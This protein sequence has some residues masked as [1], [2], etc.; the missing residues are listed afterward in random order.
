MFIPSDSPDLQR[1]L[2]DAAASAGL[3]RVVPIPG[4]GYF[5][6]PARSSGGTPAVASVEC[7]CADSA[8][9]PIEPSAELS[10]EQKA[11]FRC[12]VAPER[13]DVLVI[14]GP[15]SG[16]TKTLIS[17]IVGAVRSGTPADKI[18]AISFT[19]NS[20]AELKVRLCKA[21]KNFPSLHRVHVST[22]HAWVCQLAASR[23][24]PWTYPPVRL[25]DASLAVALHITNPDST[26]AFS[27]TE[28]MAADRHLEGCETFWAMIGRNYKN[29]LE[30]PAKLQAFRNLEAAAVTAS[31][32]FQ[33]KQISTYGS[34][35]RSGIALAKEL[36]EDGLGWLF[37]DEAQDLNS[38]QADFA[39]SVQ[40]KTKCRI[41]AIADDDQG[42]YKFRGASNIFLDALRARSATTE[43]FG[44]TKNFRS[45]QA[46]VSLCRNWIRPN[47][48]KSCA[49]EKNYSSQRSGL[50]TVILT[51]SKPWDRG[52]HA[53]IL[54]DAAQK[55][56]GLI[57]H[58]GHSAALTFSTKNKLDI[59]LRSH[60]QRVHVLKE[61]LLEKD[62]LDDFL[63]KLTGSDPA[64]NW[65]HPIWIDF[66]ESVKSAQVEA[67]KKTDKTE[68]S[69]GHPGLNDLYSA[70]EVFR[71][72]AP[73]LSPKEAADI[74]RNAAVDEKI[75]FSGEGM[76]PDYAGDKINYLTL[77]SCKGLEFRVV[78][79]CGGASAFA[80]KT[81][82]DK[83][84]QPNTS[85]KAQE[86][87]KFEDLEDEKKKLDRIAD[88]RARTKEAFEQENRRLLYVGMSRATDLLILS[89][90]R[91]SG[92]KHNQYMIRDNLFRDELDKALLGAH[93][94]KI[95]T[96]AEAHAFAAT[97][98]AAHR[99][100][101]WQ[102]PHRYRVESFT[103]LTRQLQPGENR[104]V[105]IPRE[106][107]YPLP[108]SEDAMIGDL[109]HRIMHL[110]CMEPETLRQRLD[111]KMTDADLIARVSTRN[112]ATELKPLA[113]FLASYFADFTN[114]PW[115]LLANAR[116][117][118]PFSH[119]KNASDSTLSAGL[120]GRGTR[121]ACPHEEKRTSG[122]LVP[123]IQAIDETDHEEFLLKGFL[124]LVRF[125]DDGAPSLILDYKTGPTPEP[126]D[127]KHAAQLRCYREALAESYSCEIGAIKL[128]NYYVATQV[129]RD[130]S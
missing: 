46:I 121:P 124:D 81:W 70:V 78:W 96:D 55:P 71:R 56:G 92:A 23:I 35:M 28:I 108:Q 107:E 73:D 118:V 91:H 22:F 12:V 50:P 7:R 32:Q 80:P 65:H 51:A 86:D 105:E 76:Q 106:R 26:Q 84:G 83:D 27:R 126:D 36:D 94:I 67:A 95:S 4:L 75:G 104:E 114:K 127:L 33:E 102:P 21:A 39:F 89:A 116:S 54:F 57:E 45:T 90:P 74:L 8:T 115:E 97:I 13:K 59:E 20:A 103:S 17:C 130:R 87:F 5:A 60:A 122:P 40:Q 69:F 129:L 120:P 53:M 24:D 38:T 125:G 109:F 31:S 77:H 1:K 14:A 9:S 25:A 82:D 18:V 30:D 37:I 110:L 16:K 48:E 11:V 58:F 47:W 52:R 72:L 112:P 64:T 41:F 10:E 98:T 34:L 88:M 85:N 111:S 68:T 44:L 29:V 99:H 19:N 119:V 49:G 113:G 61:R 93:Y 101:T 123:T 128:Q 79:I 15:G 117:E 62:V 66:L 42:I 43:V 3:A 100:P 63:K 6:Q 2:T